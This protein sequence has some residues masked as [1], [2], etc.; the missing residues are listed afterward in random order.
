MKTGD[1]PPI[2]A[3]A[4]SG[5][6]LCGAVQDKV[7]KIYAYPTARR[8]KACMAVLKTMTRST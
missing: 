7:L 5:K 6:T 8:C 3:H 4:T 1:K 2:H